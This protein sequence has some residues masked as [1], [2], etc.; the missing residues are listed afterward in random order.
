[1]TWLDESTVVLMNWDQKNH[2]QARRGNKPVPGHTHVEIE[3]EMGLRH[4]RRGTCGYDESK[5][6]QV[7]EDM[8]PVLNSSWHWEQYFQVDNIHSTSVT[9]Q[10][11]E[12]LQKFKVSSSN[13]VSTNGF[14]GVSIIP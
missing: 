8:P 11:T 5:T 14:I 10:V 7:S 12:Q 6:I 2:E 9:S 1:M 4:R 13:G 3:E